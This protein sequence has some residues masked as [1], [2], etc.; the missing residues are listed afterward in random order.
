MRRTT[1]GGAEGDFFRRVDIVFNLFYYIE[2]S[3][4]VSMQVIREVRT[5]LSNDFT[6]HVPDEFLNNDVEI[7]IKKIKS[8]GLQKK[9]KSR[10]E[11][12]ALILDTRGFKFNREEAN[13]R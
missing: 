2:E 4:G 1:A 11:F 6:L 10:P 9:K 8:K 3:G 12:K 5:V 13:E 7:V